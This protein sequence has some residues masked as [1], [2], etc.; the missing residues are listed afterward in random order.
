MLSVALDPDE[1]PTTAHHLL[2]LYYSTRELT[3]SSDAI[4][5]MAEIFRKLSHRMKC[6]FLGGL[7]TSAFD[8]SLLFY[9]W[10]N[11][12][13]HHHGFPSYSWSGWVGQVDW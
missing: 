1:P 6:C 4:D 3:K 2:V 13:E 12:L 10:E 7:P 9:N 5:A 8:I 11:V